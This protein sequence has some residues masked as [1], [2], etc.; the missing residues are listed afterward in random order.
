MAR[1]SDRN[2]VVGLDIGTSKVA[3][4]VGEVSDEGDVE[5]IGLG[6]HPSRGLKK[7]VVVNLEDAVKSI[8]RAVEEAELMAG[9][10]IQSVYAGISGSHINSMNSHGVVAVRDRKEVT[11]SDMDRVIDSASAVAVP[12]DQR[13][14]H[15]YPQEFVIDTHEGVRNPVGMAGIRLEARVHIITAA[16]SAAQNIARCI[17]RCGLVEEDII[18]EQMASCEAV[19]NED[20]KTLGVCLLDIGGGTT[21][22]AVY[23]EGSIR[24]TAVIPI[25]GDLVTHDIAYALRMP[26]QFAEQIKIRHACAS[27]SQ[28]SL[29]EMLEV[30]SIGDRPPR[31]ISRH[32]LAEN[33]GPRYEELLGLVRNELL[34]A[35][36][37]D[38]IPAGIVLCGG[39]SQVEGLVDLAEEIF[40]MPV[41]IGHPRYVTGLEEAL[42]SPAYATGVGLV[43]HGRQRV[44][45]GERSTSTRGGFGAMLKKMKSWFNGNF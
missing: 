35:G 10:S 38:L 45:S 16:V 21:D 23:T 22:I 31:Q 28:A 9:C 29:E 15:I 32:A 33:V 36:F 39:S 13:I 41:R 18:L 8:Q 20:E 19:L 17:E 24:H 44:I 11:Q 26:T 34:R 2:L 27:V 42:S 14:L 5:I 30:A 25:A 40:H 4:I 6:N 1:N 37:L 3:C 12:A 43:L 7:G